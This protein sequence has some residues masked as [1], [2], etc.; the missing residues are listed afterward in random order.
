MPE[1][2]TSQP[3]VKEH[4]TRK[5]WGPSPHELGSCPTIIR[6]SFHTCIRFDD[7]R[8][9]AVWIVRRWSRCVG[10]VGVIVVVI[11]VIRDWCNY[12]LTD[13]AALRS[14][15]GCWASHLQHVSCSL[16]L[17][18]TLLMLVIFKTTKTAITTS[19]S[20]VH[21]VHVCIEQPGFSSAYS[22]QVPIAMTGNTNVD[23]LWFHLHSN[24]W[25]DIKQLLITDK[26]SH[27]WI[28]L[29]ETFIC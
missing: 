7:G 10:Y 11:T 3:R 12:C 28:F 1:H 27:M 15:T 29:S 24:A 6:S 21:T 2:Q 23:R 22:K 25:T 18:T 17:R 16:G 19:I 13:N 14:L 5:K 20:A 8:G 9:V 4:W 26:V